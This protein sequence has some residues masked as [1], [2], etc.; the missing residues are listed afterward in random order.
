MWRR[1]ATP[2]NNDEWKTVPWGKR[3]KTPKD[4]LL[5]ILVSL[6]GVL[7]DVDRLSDDPRN[8]VLRAEIVKECRRVEK[9]LTFWAT[10]YEDLIY[11]P[12]IDSVPLTFSSLTVAYMTVVYWTTSLILHEALEAS[13]SEASPA[14]ASRSGSRKFARSI[15]LAVPYFFQESCGLWGAMTIAFPMAM[16]LMSL[17]RSSEAEDKRFLRVMVDAWTDPNIPSLIRDFLR[18]MRREAASVWLNKGW[19]RERVEA[20]FQEKVVPQQSR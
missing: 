20:M 3:P 14:P 7:E 6:P 4:L 19:S 15:A 13:L 16:S 18:S 12:W 11:R 10:R 9:E 17:K 8:L 5:D 1:K 2:L